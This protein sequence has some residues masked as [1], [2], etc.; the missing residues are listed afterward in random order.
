MDRQEIMPDSL[1]DSTEL[2]Y[3][4]AIAAEGRLYVSG[5]IATD[6]DGAVVGDDIETQTRQA[7][8]NLEAILAEVDRGFEDVVKVTSYLPHIHR[9]YD[10]YKAVFAD[11]FSEQL[12]AHTMLGVKDLAREELL[13]EIE[14]EVPLPDQ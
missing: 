10:G 5:Q 2:Q 13:V 6:S 3:I 9:D 7:F 1:Y 11:V 8:D 12:P 14:I 4:H